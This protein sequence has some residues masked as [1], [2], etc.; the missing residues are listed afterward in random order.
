MDWS[1]SARSQS[2]LPI[3]YFLKT[4]NLTCDCNGCIDPSGWFSRSILVIEKSL[5]P[6]ITSSIL[7]PPPP[8]IS[9]HYISPGEWRNI[10]TFYFC[11]F[12]TL[13]WLGWFWMNHICKWRYNIALYA[14][15]SE[16]C[17]GV[18]DMRIEILKYRVYLRSATRIDFCIPMSATNVPP[19]R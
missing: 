8:A 13:S 11:L 2:K 4:N 9:S 7:S 12:G 1:E 3:A 17:P 6:A 15:I 16:N 5:L 18:A 14:K 19:Q 10:L